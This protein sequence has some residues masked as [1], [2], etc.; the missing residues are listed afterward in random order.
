MRP[1]HHTPTKPIDYATLS[2][3]YGALL[4]TVVLAAR[5]R[6]VE[7]VRAA[8]LAPL[9]LAA[10]TL[11]K[12]VAKEKVE[13][14]VRAPFVDEPS[15]EP[16]GS[17]LRYAIGELLTCTRCLG[18]WSS[19]GLVALRVARPRESR[20]VTAVLATSAV[21]DWLQSG[22]T[23]LCTEADDAAAR[24]DQRVQTLRAG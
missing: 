3:T 23:L 17:G 7:P 14:W 11:S 21:N 13:S 24:R 22:F 4:G 15:R 5:D 6:G 20:V 8:E 9:G 1:V 12:L 2:A 16:K 18:A 19:L 10:F